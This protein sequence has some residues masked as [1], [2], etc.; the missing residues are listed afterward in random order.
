MVEVDADSLGVPL[1]SVV[2]VFTDSRSG[3]IIAKIAKRIYQ[4]LSQEHWNSCA[5]LDDS[6]K[7]SSASAW[8][9]FIP[10]NSLFGEAQGR[11]EGLRCL[12]CQV[13]TIF[14]GSKCILCA[15]CV[16]I[17]PENCLRLVDRK[18]T[19]LNSSHLGI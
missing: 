7:N 4:G 15:G 3:M 8:R 19:R 10:T 11:A 13:N 2:D 9:I 18:S 16:D 6:R 5:F 12:K 14:D 1:D 17:C